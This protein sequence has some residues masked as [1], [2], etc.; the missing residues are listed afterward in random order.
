MITKLIHTGSAMNRGSTLVL[1]GVIVLIGL[2]VLAICTIALPAAIRAELADGRDFD[3]GYIF[4][5]MY[6]SAVPFFV[7]LY[8]TMKLLSYIDMDRAFSTVS[9]QALKTVK[10]CAATI[11][12]LYAAGMPYIFYV[13]DRD[14]APG[15]ALIGFVIIFASFV[16]AAAVA[17]LQ[18]L[19]E[20]AV[21]LKTE[22]ELTV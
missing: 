8:Q 17:V 13:A 10:Y 2:V 19:V 9:V 18:K 20:H 7:A 11:S 1:R 6:L 5:G 14:D 16:I 12:A 21:A 3:Y 4:L 15:V 22:N